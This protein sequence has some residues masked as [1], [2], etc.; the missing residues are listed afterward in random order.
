MVVF[1]M[2]SNKNIRELDGFRYFPTNL[3]VDLTSINIC[4]KTLIPVDFFQLN[5][6]V[7]IFFSEKSGKLYKIVI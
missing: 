6:G 5:R 4:S 3:L 2:D 7:P 1:L